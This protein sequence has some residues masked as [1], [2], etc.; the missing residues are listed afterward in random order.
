M[1]LF[2]VNPNGVIRRYY[3]YCFGLSIRFRICPEM[4]FLLMS[5][6]MSFSGWFAV[7]IILMIFFILVSRYFY[8]N[9]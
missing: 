5:S 8:D 1:V 3:D 2:L 6:G 7:W 4:V 9:I